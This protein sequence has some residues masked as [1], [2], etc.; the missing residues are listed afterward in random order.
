[1][2]S[3]KPVYQQLADSIRDKVEN[4]EYHPGERIASER[5]MAESYGINRLT[6]R[7]A[8]DVLIRE[9]LLVSLQGSGTYVTEE[10]ADMRRMVFG[11]GE[12]LSL[13]RQLRQSGFDSSRKVLAFKRVPCDGKLAECFADARYCYELTRLSTIDETPYAL[14]VGIF[15]DNLFVQPERFNF[16]DG[17]LYTY[18]ELQGHRPVHIMET[19]EAAEIPDPYR[20]VLDMP[21]GS[22]VF[23][24]EYFGYDA[25]ETL[26]EWTKAYYRPEYT[27]FKF[28]A[29]R[30]GIP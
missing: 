30:A 13:S 21:D 19:M 1:M 5:S 17:S 9:G 6:V 20:T 2:N 8:I 7:K 4:G 15:P 18:M 29:S 26:V 16:A 3:A 24:C 11:Q 23:Y 12:E 27:S 14:Q 28:S 22:L 25:D 10:G